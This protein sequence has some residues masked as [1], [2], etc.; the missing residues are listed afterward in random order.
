MLGILQISF[1]QNALINFIAT[2]AIEI[3][4]SKSTGIF[5]FSFSFDDVQ[6][7]LNEKHYKSN[8]EIKSIS[9]LLSKKLTHVRSVAIKEI[10]IKS[11]NSQSIDLSDIQNFLRI[12]CQKIIKKASIKKLILN[13]SSI[14]DIS[15]SL[16][17]A[18][19]LRTTKF[20]INDKKYEAQMKLQDANIILN[21]IGTNININL[22]YGLIDKRMNIIYSSNYVKMLSFDGICFGN[23]VRGLLNSPNYDQQ[24]LCQFTIEDGRILAKVHEKSIGLSVRFAYNL[25][26][27]TLSFYETSFYNNK[28]AVM[29]FEI[30]I[31]K[32]IPNIKILLGA[33]NIE[34]KGVNLFSN[35]PFIDKIEIKDVSLSTIFGMEQFGP[36]VISGTGN[37]SNKCAHFDVRLDKLQLDE[38]VA[39]S[40][41]ITVD[42][43]KDIINLVLKYNFLKKQNTIEGYIS[44]K[45]WIPALDSKIKIKTHGEFNMQNYK[46]DYSQIVGGKLTY[47]IEAIGTILNPICSGEIKI[48]DFNYINSSSNTFIKNGSVL[49]ILKNNCLI[50]EKIYA[51]DDASPHGTI[52]GG[53]KIAINNGKFSTDISFDLHDFDIIEVNEFYGKLNGRVYVKGDTL[54]TIKVSGELYSENAKMDISNLIMKSSRSIE[55]LNAKKS[56]TSVIKNDHNK[57]LPSQWQIDVKFVFKNGLKLTGSGIDSFWEG[58]ISI[59]GSVLNVEYVSKLRMKS[60]VINVSGKKFNLKHG[61]IWTNS[62]QPDIINVRVTAVKSLD[63][64]KVGARFIQNAKG[65]HVT[66]F[67]KPYL[68][69]VDVLSL[70]LFDKKSSEISSGEAITLFS[71]MGRLTNNES[72][73]IIDRVKS[74]FG[75]DALEFKQNTDSPGQTAVSIGKNLGAMNI[76]IDQ[77]TGKDSTKIVVERKLT[78]KTKVTLDMSGKNSIGAGFAWNHRY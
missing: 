17:N 26:E 33:G 76:S 54:S 14:R 22:M 58:G 53:G 27:E 48:K 74:V 15:F 75:I 63:H 66:F 77:G 44:S 40:A 50:L 70:L 8:I 64:I 55:I 16:D 65:T 23:S 37:F 69:K 6:I 34:V 60:G 62:S 5:P 2:D 9:V 11:N 47:N 73:D 19:N 1:F 38:M 72:L 49:A 3:S 7:K 18:M 56:V 4:I 61:E 32:P 46:L 45:N 71:I 13:N 12:G 28:I 68:P 29:P 43:R 20:T 57:A 39:P 24:L 31:D 35:T 78:K 36:S 30:S 59:F 41:S 51:T 25:P 67:S 10:N 52:V 42:C 21:V